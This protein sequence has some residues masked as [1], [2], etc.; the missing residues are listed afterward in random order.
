MIPTSVRI[1]SICLLGLLVTGCIKEDTDDCPEGLYQ[2][3]FLYYDEGGTSRVITEKENVHVY[4]FH[5]DGSYV[6]EYIRTEPELDVFQGIELDLEPGIYELVCWTNQLDLS[7]VTGGGGTLD[8]HFLYQRE[9]LSG[10]PIVNFDSLY[11][12]RKT[13]RVPPR[14]FSRDTVYFRS[15][16]IR[17]EVYIEGLNQATRA[18]ND[19]EGWLVV[20]NVPVGYDFSMQLTG[21]RSDMYPDWTDSTTSGRL[22]AAFN[23]LRFGND[24]SI[25]IDIYNRNGTRVYT[26]NLQEFLRINNIDVEIRDDLTI[27]IYVRFSG[28]YVHLSV[29][30]WDSEVVIP[31]I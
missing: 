30:E 26:I 11:Y 20:R 9:Y 28:P 15:A 18:V 24:N 29:D 8:E 1:W 25:L 16:H 12:G 7:A 4:I 14:I 19:P 17:M 10:Q 3:W 31:I 23:L 5:S 21:E 13:I 27:P 6:N 2:V 22:V